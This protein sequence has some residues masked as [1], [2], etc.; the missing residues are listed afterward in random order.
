MRLLLTDYEICWVFSDFQTDRGW[1]GWYGKVVIRFGIHGYK[2][3][4]M[5]F[6]GCWGQV[7]IV[8][9]SVWSSYFD[10]VSPHR[11]IMFFDTCTMNNLWFFLWM[12]YTWLSLHGFCFC[13]VRGHS[14]L[15]QTWFRCF[16]R[17]V[18]VGSH[19]P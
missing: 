15:D 16:V 10:E 11:Y 19:S 18:I 14:K 12:F 1:F 7:I 17:N 9:R 13:S 4:I 6:S 5:R 8:W 2:I 3:D